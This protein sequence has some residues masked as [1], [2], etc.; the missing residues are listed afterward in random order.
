MEKF[1][2][3]KYASIILLGVCGL[4]TAILLGF[5]GYLYLEWDAPVEH[6]PSILEIKLPVMNLTQYSLLSK[7]HNDDTIHQEKSSNINP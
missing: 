5:V 7:Q 2:I 4:L 1:D 3:K 6:D